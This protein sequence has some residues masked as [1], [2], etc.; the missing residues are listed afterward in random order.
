MRK[1]LIALF[2]TL[3][4]ALPALAEVPYLQKVLR[5]DEMIFSGPSYDEFCVGTVKE[6]GTFTI[7]EESDDGEGHLWGRLKSGA[8]WIDLTHVRSEAIAD[9]PVSAAFAEDCPPGDVY[10]RFTAEESEYTV[11]L[12]FRAYEP[13]TAVQL[14]SLNM[15]AEEGFAIEEPLCALAAFTPDAPLVAGVTFPGDMSAY[16][17]LFI[18]A[19]GVQRL[20]AVSIS[21]RN[22]MLLL[23][24]L[25]LP[26]PECP[27]PSIP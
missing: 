21:G 4:L 1:A 6:K 12:A 24:E 19:E 16:G 22:G 8:G 17:L 18:D 26:A 2:V 25:P 23:E 13:L 10:H 3:C 20:F 5:P 11:W 9:W 14:V 15:A 27:D 7:V